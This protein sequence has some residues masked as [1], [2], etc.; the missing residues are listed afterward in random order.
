MTRPPSAPLV[1]DLSRVRLFQGIAPA[2][3]QAILAAAHPVR[4]P[5]A[6]HF[7]E[8]GAVAGFFHVLTSGRVKMTQ[9]TPEGHQVVLRLVGPGDAFGGVAAFGDPVYPAGAEAIEASASLAWDGA[10]MARLLAD[11][12]A[13]AVNALH[14]VADRLHDLQNLYRQVITERVERRVARAL[15]RLARDTGRKIEGGVLIDIPLS[16]EDLAEMTGT[17]IFTVSR[18]ISAWEEKG[19]VEG[20]RQRLVIRRPHG[21]VAIAEDL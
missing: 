10:S 7:F 16:R 2:E 1:P 12:A 20:G 8:Q 18:L 15:L 5:A 9:I 11:H 21:L 17:T 6:E 14:F 3:L 4:K 13:L 19:L